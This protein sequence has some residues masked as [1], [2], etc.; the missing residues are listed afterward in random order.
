MYPLSVVL[1]IFHLVGVGLASLL[2][3]VVGGSRWENQT[4]QDDA[5]NNWLVP[6]G[7]C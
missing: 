3:Y 2:T 7:R 4:P 6:L 5:A 1:A